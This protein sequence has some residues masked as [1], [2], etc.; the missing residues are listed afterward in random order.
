MRKSNSLSKNLEVEFN[1]SES[2]S[3]FEFMTDLSP[4]RYQPPS[5]TKVL[6]GFRATGSAGKVVWEKINCFRKSRTWT[7]LGLDTC[8]WKDYFGH[9]RDKHSYVSPGN[10]YDWWWLV[11][12]R[13]NTDIRSEPLLR[14]P[15]I[16][17]TLH[18]SIESNDIPMRSQCHNWWMHF[19]RRTEWHDW[20]V[21][22][23]DSKPI[24]SHPF[25]QRSPVIAS[26]CLRRRRSWLRPTCTC[27]SPR[28]PQNYYWWHHELDRRR[29]SHNQCSMV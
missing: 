9:E 13:H 24:L 2:N 14:Y 26:M 17:V 11:N 18:G 7:C 23:I 21:I 27:M 28:Y 20:C 4:T 29:I 12:D 25:V 16:E 15:S 22:W 5:S 19:Y 6:T 3:L 1:R 10:G 8:F